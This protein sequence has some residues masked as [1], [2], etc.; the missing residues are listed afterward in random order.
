MT[1]P[2]LSSRLQGRALVYL[3]AVG[4]TVGVPLGLWLART[5]AAHMAMSAVALDGDGVLALPGERFGTISLGQ[6]PMDRTTAAEIALRNDSTRTLVIDGLRATCP[7]VTSEV[8]ARAI[9]PGGTTTLRVLV[10]LSEAKRSTK[11]GVLLRYRTDDAEPGTARTAVVR[12]V[13]H[14][15]GADAPEPEDGAPRER[16]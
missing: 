3:M 15:P 12:V 7:C 6:V 16:P 9:P 14:V 2:N 13:A 11:S 8:S 1:A 5:R 10:T 4:A